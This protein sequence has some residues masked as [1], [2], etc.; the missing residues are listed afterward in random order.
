MC[1]FLHGERL[2]GLWVAGWGLGHV[3]VWGQSEVS[4]C[5]RAGKGDH[6]IQI[7]PDLPQP[8]CR[9]PR[10]QSRG[11]HAGEEKPYLADDHMRAASQ[12]S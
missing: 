8:L 3:V 9:E 2:S 11:G 12:T 10:R 5:D 4:L 7:C 6:L 1:L